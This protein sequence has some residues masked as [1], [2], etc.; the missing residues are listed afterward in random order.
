MIQVFLLYALSGFVSLGYQVAWFRIFTDWFGSTNLTFALVV[1]NFIGGLA[2]GAILSERITDFFRGRMKVG[3]G[4]RI[5]GLIELL[6]ATTV[7][8]TVLAEF[9]PADLWGSFPYVLSDGIWVQTGGYRIF[10]VVVAAICVFVPC[11]FMGVTFPLLC[12][13][14][15]GKS[16]GQR[17]PAAIYAWNTLGAGCGVLVAQFLLLPW[18]GHKDT[19][20]AMVGLNILIGAYF[21]LAGNTTKIVG[22]VANLPMASVSKDAPAKSSTLGVLLMCAALSGLLSGA[23]EG[24]MFKRI[25][26]VIELNPGATMS[27]ISFWAI[28]AIFLASTVVHRFARLSLTHI[29]IACVAA[30][31]Y[32]VAASTFIDQIMALVDAGF[33]AFPVSI[34]QQRAVLNRFPNDLTELLIF[35]GILVFPP[36][37]LISLLLPYV[38]NR[39]QGQGQHIGLAYGLNT[40]AFCAGLIGFTLLAPRV[41]IFFSLKLFTL[42]FVIATV[43]LILIR[44]GHRLRLWQ[45]SVLIIGVAI[46]A[47]LTST[48]FDRRFFVPGSPPTIF[49]VSEL[50]SNSASTTFV[51]NDGNNAALYF[52]RLKMSATTNRATTYMRLMAHFP[53][54][55]HSRPEKALLICFGAGNTASAIASHDSIQQIDI[56]DLND[57]VFETAPE[58]SATNDEVHLDP[59]VRL[60]HDDGR[61]YLNLT[62]QTYDLITS[63]PPPPLAAGVYRLY[64]REY[65]SVAADHLTP[66]GLM[67]Q[68]LPLY[69]MNAEA[70]E[71]AIRTFTDVFPQT[72]IFT[73]FS[74]DFILVGSKSPIDL[75]L[76]EKRFSESRRVSSDLARLRITRPADM[77]ARIVQSD[78][79]LRQ[80]YADARI[81]SDQHN[82]LERL[83]RDRTRPAIIWYDPKTVLAYLQ[84]NVPNLRAELK[85]SVAHLGR[86]RYRVHGFPFASLATARAA[87]TSGIALANIDWIRIAEFYDELTQATGAGQ[88]RKAID[89]MQQMLGVAEE[90]PEVLIS[91]AALNLREGNLAAAMS[92]LREFRR[93]EPNDPA[94]YRLFGRALMLDG[95]ADEAI[96]QFRKAFELNPDSYVPLVRISWIL[97]T[98]PDRERRRPEEAIRLAET[99]AELTGH[100][101]AEVLNTLAAAYASAGQFDRAV[102]AAQSAID[103]FNES[104]GVALDNLHLHLRAYRN[105]QALS[106]QSLLPST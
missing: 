15:S 76:V 35:V 29:K 25:S 8:L 57:K 95:R 5:Y 84:S 34:D 54:L 102:A 62:D 90:Q 46:A 94:G 52:G 67:T 17:F 32:F 4:L 31:V 79:E 20:W 86:L 14:F 65:Y 97:A 68:W 7:L 89:I 105:Q 26:F 55:L 28:L 50:K 40:L 1:S 58:F 66:D 72:L 24:D 100:Q 81:I 30:L 85:L 10:Q 42:L 48:E 27:F 60:I 83:F 6:V 75:A 47:W 53:L 13:A 33:A 91:Y 61:N 16:G 93:L 104:A 98:H 23:L 37:F 56:V 9:L 73:G 3:D 18:L 77:L 64:S 87:D 69:L 45:P 44:E 99:A 36:Y 11:L 19:L 2:V 21:L 92:S 51:I 74:S 38:C 106:D 49:P 59:R 39:I 63:E 96:A 22:A 80:N 88:Q 12:A 82:D 70:V 41:N 101:N 103:V 43:T 71:L 78:S